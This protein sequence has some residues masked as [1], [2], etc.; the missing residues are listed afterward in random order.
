[1]GIND[2]EL[3]HRLFKSLKRLE[4]KVDNIGPTP[5]RHKLSELIVEMRKVLSEFDQE[6]YEK[7]KG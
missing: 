7:I 1:M 6:E 3:E 2:K 4:K 5:V